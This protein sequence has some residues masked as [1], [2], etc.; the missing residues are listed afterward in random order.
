MLLAPTDYDDESNTPVPTRNVSQF[1][2]LIEE[3][4][5]RECLQKCLNTNVDT[6]Q[7]RQVK[8]KALG[9]VFIIIVAFILFFIIVE[10]EI[11]GD[12]CISK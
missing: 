10:D 6:F 2:L 4:Y 9:M 8:I 12:K 5:S 1:A 7:S 11:R 3:C